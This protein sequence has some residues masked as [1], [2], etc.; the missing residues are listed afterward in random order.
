M[1]QFIEEEYKVLEVDVI[2]ICKKLDILGAK[3][4]YD[5][6][7]LFTYFNKDGKLRLTNEGTLKLSYSHDTPQG[8]EVIKVKVSRDTEMLAILKQL[9]H[10]PIA[11]IP[12]KRISYE[13][14]EVDF[15]IDEFPGLK[16]FMEIDCKKKDLLKWLEKLNLQNNEV[17]QLTTM[18]IYKRNGI[19]IFEKYRV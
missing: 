7:R 15:D 2:E 14:N 8:H 4:V 5:G 13:L 12:S 1:P 18:Q 10:N 16:P 17:V 9:G 3:K 6:P 11:K 19:D